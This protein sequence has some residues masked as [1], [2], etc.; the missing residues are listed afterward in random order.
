MV[1]EQHISDNLSV[2]NRFTFIIV[3]TGLELCIIKLLF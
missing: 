3:C 1:C 2:I